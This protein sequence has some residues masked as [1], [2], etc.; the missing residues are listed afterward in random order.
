MKVF[1]V[2]DSISSYDKDKN[3]I[4]YIREN[5]LVIYKYKNDK[6]DSKV[7]YLNMPSGAF[8]D[9]DYVPN[10][11]TGMMYEIV[12]TVIED[13]FYAGLRE[14]SGNTR[15]TIN[16][17]N[18][19]KGSAGWGNYYNLSTNHGV[20]TD[21]IKFELNLYNSRKAGI[22][23]DTVNLPTLPFTPTL[24]IYFG[25]GHMGYSNAT[26]TPSAHKFYHAQITQG[27]KLVMDLIPVR[28]DDVGCV[29]DKISGRIFGNAG[30]GSI[31][32][33]PDIE[34][35]N[36]P[37]DAEI[38]YLEPSAEG[39]N[40]EYIDTEIKPTS[41][42]GVEI[43]V[44]CPAT[45]TDNGKETIFFGAS[46]NAAYKSGNN[47]TIEKGSGGNVNAIMFKTSS[48]GTII[49]HTGHY[50]NPYILRVNCSSD[51]TNKGI[52]YNENRTQL[53]NVTLTKDA[54]LPT[55]LNLYLFCRNVAGNP[56][57]SYNYKTRIYYLK[58]WQDTTLVR[59]MIPVR[60]GNVGL[61][62]DKVSKKLFKSQNSGT[63]V[64][65]PDIKKHYNMYDSKIAYLEST[66]T[67]KINTGITYNFTGKIK[68]AATVSPINTDRCIIISNYNGG[69]ST[70]SCEFGGTSNNHAQQPRFYMSLTASNNTS[71]T[72]RPALTLNEMSEIICEY[73]KST[74]TKIFTSQGSS[75]TLTYSGDKYG[76]PP[77]FALFLDHRYSTSPIAY[78][79]RIKNV[80]I[81]INDRLVRDFEAVRI[82]ET[83]YM[84]DNVY[85][86][87]YGNNG[88]G[89]FILGPDI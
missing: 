10:N 30:T 8:F 55:A 48:S 73:D 9:S 27:T 75:T 89:D 41:T 86:K 39:A 17:G 20:I 84:F 2:H 79:V 37:Y 44:R 62:Y 85:N 22:G 5:P 72:F 34:D 33:G 80:K 67:Q 47:F 49:I 16:F 25:G 60:I 70:I 23:S 61:M 26:G 14:S 43:K 83:G 59:D 88:T 35:K 63:F 51:G 32:P 4:T 66:G 31:T 77:Q 87:L 29:Y 56:D 78:G 36:I 12:R 24:S 13:K 3:A 38:E 19:T 82:G 65:G 81:Y 28:I 74:N 76:T 69:A 68:I 64:L 71:D 40:G 46:T 1:N 6:F 21:K 50:S 7:E 53:N 42:T 15:F 58:I 52:M 45:G 18:S 11:Q 57:R 54:T